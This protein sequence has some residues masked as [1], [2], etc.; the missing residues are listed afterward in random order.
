TAQELLRDAFITKID[1]NPYEHPYE[2]AKLI[3]KESFNIFLSHKTLFLK[4][5]TKEC[6]KFFVQPMRGYVASQIG[7]KHGYTTSFIVAAVIIQVAVMFTLYSIILYALF[8]RF[9]KQISIPWLIFFI[10]VLLITFAQF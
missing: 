5:H 2:Y 3:E 6:L 1:Y 7:Y 4:E 9:K 10:L 8:L